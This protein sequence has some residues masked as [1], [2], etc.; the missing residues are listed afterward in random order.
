MQK[1]FDGKARSALVNRASSLAPR[2]QLVVPGQPDKSFLVQKLR[3]QLSSEE[4]Q[5]MPN[6][7]TPL[8]SPDI[9]TVEQWITAGA[10]AE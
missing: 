9:S 5:P 1:I 4:G 8:S 7:G 10:L 2:K 3:G 6:G